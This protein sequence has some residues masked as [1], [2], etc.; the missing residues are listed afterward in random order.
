[1]TSKTLQ[2]FNLAGDRQG[3]I[4]TRDP[5]RA[6]FATDGGAIVQTRR[7]QAVVKGLMI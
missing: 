6:L 2:W 5:I 3:E 7:H 1:L 4:S